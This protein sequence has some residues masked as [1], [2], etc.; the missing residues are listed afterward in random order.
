M[1]CAIFRTLPSFCHS[2]DADSLFFTHGG[3]DRD[4]KLFLFLEFCR[5]LLAKVSLCK[6]VHRDTCCEAVVVQFDSTEWKNLGE[7]CHDFRH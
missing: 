1:D 4:K 3:E 7:K 6:K 5:N 2:F